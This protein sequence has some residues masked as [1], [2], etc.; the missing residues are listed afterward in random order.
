MRVGAVV[1]CI[2][3]RLVAGVWLGPDERADSAEPVPGT[4]FECG[5]VAELVPLIDALRD[6]LRDTMAI[7]R[8]RVP[9]LREFASG[10][11]RRL[12]PDEVLA[13]SSDVVVVVAHSL[14]HGLPLHLVL[15][16]DGA[17]VGTRAGFSY[18]S[19]MSLF[20]RCTERNSA[21]Q[22]DHQAWTFDAGDAAPVGGFPDAR[23][24]RAGGTDVIRR[25]GSFRELAD[26]IA[27]TVAGEHAIPDDSS[28]PYERA[29]FKSAA[30]TYPPCDVAC[31]VAHGHL[32]RDDHRLSGLL[33]DRG[34]GLVS[35]SVSLYGV[36][37]QVK[38]LPLRE[39]PAST[40]ILGD[41]EVL[42]IAELAINVEL[43]CELVALLGCSAGWSRVLAGDEPASLAETMLQLGAPSVIA[44][45]WDSPYGA[46]RAWALAFTR[47]W[48][49]EGQ[50]K[51][52]AARSAQL[53]LEA[54]GMGP[55]RCGV[56]TLRGDWL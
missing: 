37:V 51:A 30:W 9:R 16:D 53:A 49:R 27:E 19:S 11:G 15:G 34:L 21:R 4:G 26:A 33:L 3:D 42:T 13:G 45:L 8:G 38:D 36:P 20:A 39:V 31:V 43:Q 7:A 6:E 25:D 10:W 5:S 44:P 24:I 50:P 29:S 14:L 1:Q 23:V 18:A 2:S 54:D 35:R 32:D 28:F 48:A 55:E 41:A 17:A 47:A 12:L 40:R 56:L 52:L 46:T 22:L